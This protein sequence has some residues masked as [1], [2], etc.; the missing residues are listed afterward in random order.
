MSFQHAMSQLLQCE[1][2]LVRQKHCLPNAQP[3]PGLAVEALSCPS[4]L[5]VEI[6]HAK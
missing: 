6:P 4:F 1:Q 3:P 2:C 5:S